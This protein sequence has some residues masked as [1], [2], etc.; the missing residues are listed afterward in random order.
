[1]ERSKNIEMN[2]EKLKDNVN[3][4]HVQ[5]S[6]WR[7]NSRIALCWAFYYVND[8]KDV[9]VRTSQTTCCIICHNNLVLNSNPKLQARK[10]TKY[11]F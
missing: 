5:R 9:N 3:K 6:F 11:F 8:N 7:V 4:L 2:E 10:E 1:M